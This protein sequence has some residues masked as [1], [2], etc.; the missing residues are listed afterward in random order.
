MDCDFVARAETDE[1]L[2]GKVA[3]HAKTEHGMSEI[4]P[5]I[6]AKVKAAIREE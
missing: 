6:V 3:E 4:P 1:E 5:D 2:M